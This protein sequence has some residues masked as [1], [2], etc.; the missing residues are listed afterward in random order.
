MSKHRGGV[1]Y[2]LLQD[3]HIQWLV[4]RL[5][6]DLDI[7]KE[8][9]HRQPNEAFHFSFLVSISGVSKAIWSQIRIILKLMHYESGKL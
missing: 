5:H 9:L 8:S 1:C 2:P 7:T 4:D 6:V 3:E